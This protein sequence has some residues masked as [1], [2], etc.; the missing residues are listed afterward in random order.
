MNVNYI[1]SEIY[2]LDQLRNEYTKLYYEF[3][4]NKIQIIF[5]VLHNILNENYERMNERLPTKEH[6]VYFWADESRNLIFAIEIIRDMEQKLK[7]SPFSFELDEYYEK[8]V[9]KSKEFLRAS[10]GSKIPPYMDKIELY[11]SLPLFIK[12]DFIKIDG[13]EKSGKHAKLTLIGEGSY[14]QVFSFKDNFYNKKFILKRAKRDLNDKELERFKRE[15]TTIESLSSPYIIQVYRYND[16]KNEYIME[17]M[18]FTLR[19]Y[20]EKNNSKITKETRKLIANQILRAFKYVH[21]K[22]LFHRD[23]SPENVLIKEYEDTIVVKISDFGLVKTPDS[24]LT[25]INTRLKGYFNDPVLA[26]EGFENYQISH[27]IY[28]L[29]KL[30]CFVMSG[31][32]NTTNIKD[33]NLREFL[34]K[35]LAAN[36]KE[37]FQSVGEMANAVKYL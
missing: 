1:G 37:R 11:Y 23:I 12:Q 32:T 5:S 17:Y 13:V 25:S 15:F 7:D 6:S 16:D 20:I 27:E 36:C 28:A 4:N 18:D 33:T 35:G 3:P 2:T 21:S 22:N 10:N 24:N 34:S 14:A 29:T 9:K 8:I 31:R 30:I 19:K 26:T